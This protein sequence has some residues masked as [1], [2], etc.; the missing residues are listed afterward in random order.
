MLGVDQGTA[1]QLYL[2]G[3]RSAA[4]ARDVQAF[5]DSRFVNF[6]ML[7]VEE[8]ARCLMDEVSQDLDPREQNRLQTGGGLRW[9]LAR[10]FIRTRA[11]LMP[12]LEDA[13]VSYLR[14]CQNRLQQLLESDA[15]ATTESLARICGR[16][17]RSL[18]RLAVR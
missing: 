3:A 9:L 8:M 2:L 4:L 17:H 16:G 1:R 7:E 14:R 10:L 6:Q 12:R 13:Y 11:A 5:T 15:S 18:E